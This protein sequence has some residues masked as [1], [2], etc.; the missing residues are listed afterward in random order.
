MLTPQAPNGSEETETPVHSGSDGQRRF[1]T[2][3]LLYEGGPH[4][5]GSQFIEGLFE[6]SL[7]II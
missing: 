6:V 3:F 1:G 4:T 2:S 7:P 5:L